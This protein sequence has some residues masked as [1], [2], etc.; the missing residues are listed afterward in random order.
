MKKLAIAAVMLLSGCAY[1]GDVVN[2]NE[3]GKARIA[4][5]RQVHS[6]SSDFKGG[7][8]FIYKHNNNQCGNNCAKYAQREVEYQREQAAKHDE[9]IA[10]L[11]AETKRQ[12][13]LDMTNRI[14]QTCL[15]YINMQINVMRA[16]AYQAA[17]T[18]SPKANEYRDMYNRSS[19]NRLTAINKCIDKAKT[20]NG[21]N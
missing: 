5:D 12:N 19:E 7:T 17:E 2:A 11:E 1:Q 20:D 9:V 4:A 18:G 10:K 21:I 8:G 16:E 15:S 6:G 14:A 3:I 13:D